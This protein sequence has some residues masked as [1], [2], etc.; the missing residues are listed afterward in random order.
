VE[1]SEELERLGREDLLGSLGSGQSEVD[2][3]REGGHVDIDF[4]VFTVL[5]EVYGAIFGV[6][7][8]L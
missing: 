1:D 3:L 7:V 5:S 2:A 6:T 4:L 8:G